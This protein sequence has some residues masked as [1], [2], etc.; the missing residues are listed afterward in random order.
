MPE[1]PEVETVRRDLKRHVLGKT[2][3]RVGIVY[4]K[5]I[6]NIAPDDFMVALQGQTISDLKRKGKYLLFMLEGA[7]LVSH[8]RMEGKYI[9]KKDEPPAK[10]EHVIF[11]FTDGS[12]LRYHDVRKFGTMDLFQTDDLESIYLMP[13]LNKVGH[14]PFDDEL[15]PEMLH[16]RFQKISKPIKTTLLDQGI[17]SGLGNSY[18]DEV[19][20]LAKIHPETSTKKLS[21]ERVA[22]VLFHAREVLKKAIALGGTTIKSF[23]SHEIS[24]RFQNELLVHTKENC[25]NCRERITKIKAGGRGTYF[26]ERCQRMEK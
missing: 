26:C 1:L 4:E 23:S 17:M 3:Q 20:F 15:T 2:I 19:C 16:E 25:P 12:S 10:H 9:L 5:I 21:L 6:R 13:P 7:V 8:L 11:H 24:G 22:A 14:D 18:A